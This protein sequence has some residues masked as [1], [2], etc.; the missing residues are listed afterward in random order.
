M[1]RSTFLIRFI[2]VGLIILFGF[3]MISD[4]NIRSHIRLPSGEEDVQRDKP[5][6]L[7][8]I[9]I[10]A[11]GRYSLTEAESET[12]YGTLSSLEELESVLIDVQRHY[13]QAEKE[14][15]AII[16]PNDNARMQWLVDVLDL[17]DRHGIAKNINIPSFTL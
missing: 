16:Y 17:C 10:R 1:R 6:T 12:G 5:L 13:R 3:V 7:I 2:D 15:A 8:I 14:I 4:I 9:E 11:D